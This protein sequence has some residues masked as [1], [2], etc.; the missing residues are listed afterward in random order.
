M[1]LLKNEIKL[2][3]S[4]NYKHQLKTAYCHNYKI[5]NYETSR[6]K[7]S[8]NTLGYWNDRFFFEEYPLPLQAQKKKKKKEKREI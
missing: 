3:L 5:G 2:A 8:R 1:H 4:S 7:Y 6:R